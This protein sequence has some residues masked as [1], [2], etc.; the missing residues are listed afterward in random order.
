[1]QVEINS[2]MEKFTILQNKELPSPLVINDRL[3]K[4]IDYVNKLNK[5]AGNQASSSKSASGL[6]ALPIG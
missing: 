4:H 2:F 5:Y 3:I 6:K 1:M